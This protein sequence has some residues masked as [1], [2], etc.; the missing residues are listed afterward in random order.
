M[1]LTQ[2]DIVIATF[3]PGRTDD[4]RAGAREVI[5]YRGQWEAAWVIEDGP[6][7]GQWA[8]VPEEH[9]KFAWCPESDLEGMAAA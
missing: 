8:M 5:G 1:A 6:Y 7:E 2:Y 9:L 3:Q 4:L